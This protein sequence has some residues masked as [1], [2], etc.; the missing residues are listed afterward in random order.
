MLL[1]QLVLVSSIENYWDLKRG[2]FMKILITGI[3]G[4]IGSNVAKHF[5]N[6]GHEV[7]GF[8]W[9][10]DQ[11][12]EKMK[13]FGCQIIT[14]DLENYDEVNKAVKGQEVIFHM[15]AAFQSG[16]PFTPNQYFDINIKGTF[17]ILE[18]SL[19]NNQLKHLIVTST[20]GTIPKYPKK[21]IE[22]PLGEFDLPQNVTD[23]YGYSKT[24][25]ENLSRRYF[26]SDKLPVSVL[27]FSMV[28]GRF[29][30]CK[31]N[32]FYTGHFLQSFKGKPEFSDVQ[33][34]LE[35]HISRG[36]NL[37]IPCDNGVSWK[38]HV[39]DIRDI[40][41]AYDAMMCNQNTFGRTY[42]IAGPKSFEW[43]EV[44]PFLSKKVNL[45][46]CSVDIPTAPTYYEFDLTS[47]KKDFNYDPKWDIFAMIDDE[48]NSSEENFGDII[49]TESDFRRGFQV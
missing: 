2:N 33:N 7:T 11:K 42:Q 19:N 4:R 18:A 45:N 20:D 38:K 14:G 10:K 25:A 34:K 44:I 47:C 46:Y 5:I 28:F 24:L 16:G 22:S 26:D 1:K 30:V 40:I 35:D 3:T 12:L 31:W 8:S 23:W 27:R 37:I 21:R 6:L 17:N 49:P 32:Q 13:N 39:I 15:G 41:H 43:S 48:L 29:E 36:E 9:S